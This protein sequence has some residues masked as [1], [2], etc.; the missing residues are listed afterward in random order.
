M[1][2]AKL[3]CLFSEIVTQIN[4]DKCSPPAAIMSHTSQVD[5]RVLLHKHML[6]RCRSTER[7]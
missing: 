3:Q 2:I 5:A 7:K 4:P 1:C 6:E